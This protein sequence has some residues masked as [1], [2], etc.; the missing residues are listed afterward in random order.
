M[1][2]IAI[3]RRGALFAAAALAACAGPPPP[4]DFD[5]WASAFC[6][7]WVRLNPEQATSLQYFAGAEQAALDARLTPRTKAA[8]DER[9]ALARSGLASLDRWSAAALSAEQRTSAAILRFA[10]GRIVASG[11]YADHGFALDQLGGPHIR[12]VSLLNETHPLR[13][14]ADLDHWL[15]RLAQVAARLDEAIE[16]SRRGADCALLPPRFIVERSLAQVQAFLDPEPAANTLVRTLERRTKDLPGLAAAARRAAIAEATQA[17]AGSVRPAYQRV[18]AYLAGLLPRTGHDAGLWRLPAG[19]KAYTERLIDHTTTTMSVDQIH[20]LGLAEVERI[21]AEIDRGLRSIGQAAGSVDERLRE[22]RRSLAPPA[23]PDPRPQ[24]LA[25]YTQYVRE[26]EQRS[27]ALFHSMPRAAVDVRRVGPITERTASAH[28]T[29]PAPDGSRPGVMWVPLPGPAFNVMGMK[30]LAVHEAVPGHHFQLALQQETLAL[31]RWR[32]LR[33]FG[34]GSAHSEGWALYAERL[35]IEQGWYEGDP[36]GLIGAWEAQRFRA[37]RLVVDTGLHARR[38]TRERAIAYGISTS[39]VER[40]VA[41]P[42]QACAYMVGMLRIRSLR[43]EAKAALGARFSLPDFHELVLRS[44][45]MPLD[46]LGDVVR[47]W[48]AAQRG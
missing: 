1:T 18:A 22:L 20:R 3:T 27:R 5:Q 41:N 19:D 43:D 47:S 35:A 33:V 45:S 42:G 25:R 44:G 38:W 21:E 34:G 11:P 24:L 15:A 30:S 10:L 14:G 26:A 48:V 31:P 9:L 40:Y 29:T 16:N 4:R 13:N 36:H 7:R 37:R 32:R 39:E 12:L 23:D 28:Y 8:R 17:V 2:A 6:D 46:V